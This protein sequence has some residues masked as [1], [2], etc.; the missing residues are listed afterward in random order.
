MTEQ[1]VKDLASGTRKRLFDKAQSV[2]DK[3]NQLIDKLIANLG[4]LRNGSSGYVRDCNVSQ[5]DDMLRE[6]IETQREL[7]E[8][9]R[10]HNAHVEQAEEGV[11]SRIMTHTFVIA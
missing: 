8:C 2:K 9:I 6:T 11:Q 4:S 3:R 10:E 1:Q 5:L 7:M